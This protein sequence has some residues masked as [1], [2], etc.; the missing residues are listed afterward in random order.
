MVVP[1]PGAFSQ[2]SGFSRLLCLATARQY[3][4]TTKLHA[5]RTRGNNFWTSFTI[6]WMVVRERMPWV[7]GGSPRSRSQ[8]RGLFAFKLSLEP[9]L[10]CVALLF[11]NTLRLDRKNE[12]IRQQITIEKIQRFRRM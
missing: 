9:P 2:V 3:C 8:K 5:A 12:C 4:W 10:V 6:C 11:L 1:D 7:G